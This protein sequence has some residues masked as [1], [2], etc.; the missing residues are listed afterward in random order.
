MPVG[1]GGRNR[2]LHGGRLIGAVV[3]SA[4]ALGAL[5][6]MLSVCL[7]ALSGALILIAKL[8]ALSGRMGSVVGLVAS[9]FAFGYTYWGLELSFGHELRAFGLEG[10]V[11]AT[12]GVFGLMWGVALSHHLLGLC[13]QPGIPRDASDTVRTAL[14]AGLLSWL[15]TPLRWVGIHVRLSRELLVLGCGVVALVLAGLISALFPEFEDFLDRIQFL[16]VILIVLFAV[17]AGRLLTPRRPRQWL[18]QAAA[19]SLLAMACVIPIARSHGE[20]RASRPKVF[21]YDPLGKYSLTLVES[22]VPLRESGHGAAT[23]PPQVPQAYPRPKILNELRDMR[24]LT[25]VVLWDAARPDHMSLYGYKRTEPPILPTTPSMDAHKDQLLVFTQAYSQAT[26]TSCSLRHLFTGRYSSRW[27]LQTDR[28]DPFWTNELYNAGYHTLHLNIIG[29]DYNSLSIKAFYRDMPDEQ[30]QRL[31]V[32]D[33]YRCPPDNRKSVPADE[34]TYDPELP[35]RPGAPDLLATT[36][37]RPR[38]IECNR[39]NEGEAVDDLLAFLATQVETGGR[40]VFA[41][42]H[43]DATH[44]PWARFEEVEDFGSDQVNRFDQAIRYSDLITGRLIDGLKELGFWD[45][46]LFLVT[47]DHGSGLN[48]HGRYGGFHPWYE[49][50]HIPLA[51]RVP[52]VPGRRIDTM[53]GL[54]D[55]GATLMDLFAPHTLDRYDGRSL[56]PVILGQADRRRRILFGLNSFDDCYYLVDSDGWHYIWHRRL[57]YEQLYNYKT[58]PAERTSLV[59]RNVEITNQCRRY[60]KWFLSRPGADRSYG[61]PYHFRGP[62]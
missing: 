46:T 35:Q 50:I 30:K 40:G 49:Q 62:D 54:F 2:H 3:L 28:I 5:G 20:L 38:L 16:L 27:M 51:I 45:Q 44:T 6:L 4:A 7:A 25:I 57:N 56:W 15:L 26:A 1:V 8:G 42:I 14:L 47:A 9:L 59:G 52:G 32:F 21:R 33:C 29:S 55:L 34:Q 17:L 37:D 61:H 11:A 53:V 10:L 36:T 22:L 31:A 12:I 23:P 41:F 18:P 13:R 43:M 60:M 48:E 24:P 39:Q 58:D 19:V